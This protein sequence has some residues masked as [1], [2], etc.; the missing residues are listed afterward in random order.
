VASHRETVID[1][2]TRQAP[3]FSAAPSINDAS[4]LELLVRASGAG[5]SDRVLDV[6][7]GPGIVACAFATVAAH[8]AGLD[9]VD[10]MLDRAR[11]RAAERGLCNVEW[12]SGD[13]DALPWDDGAFD[14]VVS[15]F[16]LHHLEQPAA[17]VA[18]MARVCAPGGRVVVCD[19]APD[20]GTARAFNELERLRDPSHVRALTED[21]L[22]AL[23]AGAAALEPPTVARTALA[24]EL[25]SHLARS[26]P[27]DPGDLDEVRRM[28]IASLDDDRLGIVA[29]RVGDG[30]VYAYPLAVLVANRGAP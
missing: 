5:A 21:E 13:V 25:E 15:R 6:A 14:V 20:P 29:D 19:L 22:R 28:V 18:E 4:L 11:E 17:A 23:L 27:L 8:V 9:L 30:I 26:F 3:A 1:Q 7:C 12:V 16:A 2:F 24:I 10:A